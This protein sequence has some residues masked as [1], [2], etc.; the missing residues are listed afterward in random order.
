MQNFTRPLYF[1]FFFKIFL[2]SSCEPTVFSQ[3]RP[4]TQQFLLQQEEARCACLNQY[5]EDFIKKMDE[6]IIYIKGLSKQYDLK[7]LSPLEEAQ[8]K[9]GLVPATSFIKT[10]SNCIAKRTPE[11]DEL[12]GLLIQEDLRVVLELDSTLS[13]QEHLRKLNQPSIEVLEANCPEQVKAVTR[14]QD[15]IEAASVLPP[16]LQ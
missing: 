15:L 16:S 6:G 9:I 3:L 10:V 8:I 14:L 1:F 13:D 11:V 5:G 7:N 4:E 12:T 2:L